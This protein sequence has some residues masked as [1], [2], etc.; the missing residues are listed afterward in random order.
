M[1]GGK[2]HWYT[3][4][5]CWFSE[6]VCMPRGPIQLR[7][8]YARSPGS[9]Q[10]QMASSGAAWPVRNWP[11]FCSSFIAGFISPRPEKVDPHTPGPVLSKIYF[12][13]VSG[14][15]HPTLGL[16]SLQIP[17]RRGSRIGKRAFW[18]LTIHE[19]VLVDGAPFLNQHTR[20]EARLRIKRMVFNSKCR[21][22]QYTEEALHLRN[23]SKFF[24]RSKY[25]T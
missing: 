19:Y 8:Y 5:K 21:R 1:H 17:L 14:H 20:Q 24:R 25:A 2:Q 7:V 22:H 15:V 13:K 18:L 9:A 23:V 6:E 16:A 11:T 12:I 4:P 10:R 3:H